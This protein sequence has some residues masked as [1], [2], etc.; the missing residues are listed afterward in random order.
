M[1]APALETTALAV[2]YRRRRRRT[3]VFTGLDLTVP[4]GELVCLVG[5]TL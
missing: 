2:G 4:P 1:T 5:P 3:T